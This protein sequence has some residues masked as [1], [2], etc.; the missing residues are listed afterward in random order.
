MFAYVIDMQHFV[1][2]LLFTKILNHLRGWDGK[3][4]GSHR[5]S[6]VAEKSNDIRPRL[7]YRRHHS[8]KFKE[9]GKKSLNEKDAEHVRTNKSLVNTKPKKEYL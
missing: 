3:L 6:R 8:G 7:F 5:D 1:T 4:I 9:I 2:F